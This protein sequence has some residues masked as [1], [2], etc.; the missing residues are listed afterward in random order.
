METLNIKDY[1]NNLQ[2][3]LSDKK[4]TVVVYNDR[5]CVLYGADVL[6]DEY[7]QTH[8]IIKYKTHNFGGTIVNFAGDI[9]IGNYQ[10]DFNN[11][12][13]DFLVNFVKWLNGKGLNAQFVGNDVLIDDIYKVASFMSQYI[14]GCLYTAIHLS[15][16]MDI[17]L[18][19]A[20]CTKPMNKIPKGLTEHGI[21][22]QEVNKFVL[23]TLGQN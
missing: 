6:N 11:F 7:C 17:E 9:C 15:V 12:G 19:K 18:I 20:I 2:R 21:T 1:L 16:N 10:P 14:N 8:S 4:D 5:T 22:E 23:D 3:Y 13:I